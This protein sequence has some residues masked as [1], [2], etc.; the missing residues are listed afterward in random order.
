[1]LVTCAQFS[2]ATP[3]ACRPSLLKRP[4]SQAQNPPTGT[5]AAYTTGSRG[6]SGAAAITSSIAGDGEGL[7]LGLGVGL[8]LGLGRGEGEGEGVGE[9]DGDGVGSAACVVSA[10]QQTCMLAY[11]VSLYKA[12]ARASRL[13]LETTNP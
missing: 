11:K 12:I 7:G 4:F 10:R 6:A 2:S 5:F 13:H 8:G 3:S 1:M 9:G